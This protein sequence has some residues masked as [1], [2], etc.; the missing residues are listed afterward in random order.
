MNKVYEV[1]KE[2]FERSNESKL[3]SK[4]ISSSERE[5]IIKKWK[6]C[7]ESLA[8]RANLKRGLREEFLKSTEGYD[9]F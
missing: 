1:P 6:A 8:K 7:L 3:E 4:T 5:Q 2:Y 9:K